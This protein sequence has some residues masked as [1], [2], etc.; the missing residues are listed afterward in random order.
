MNRRLQRA[1]RLW[2]PLRHPPV[3]CRRGVHTGLQGEFLPASWFYY[4]LTAHA[5]PRLILLG[6]IG[7][8]PTLMS[9]LI[10]LE[11]RFVF[12]GF[13]VAAWITACL[14]VGYIWRPRLTVGVEIPARVEAGSRFEIRYSV[15]NTGR[16]TARDLGVDT[17]VYSD[18]R[19]LRLQPAAIDRVPAG[20]TVLASGACRAL[21]RGSYFLPGLRYDSGFPGGLWRWGRTDPSERPLFVYPRYTRLSSFEIPLG[22]R[23]RQELSHA[24]ERAREA[25]EFH[26]CREFRDGDA[27]RHVHPRSSAR[28]GAPVVKEFQAEGRARTAILVDTRRLGTCRQAL[29]FLRGNDPVEAGLSIA[30]AVVDALAATD[31]VLELLVAGP[32]V[33]RFRSAGRVGYLSEALDILAAVEP[34]RADPL[35]RL[36]P[37]L[38]EEIRQIQSVCLILTSWDA[39]RAELIRRLEAWDTGLKILLLSQG[40]GRPPGFPPDGVCLDARAVLRGEEVA[41]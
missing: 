2:R 7:L 4:W 20:A 23:H 11:S 33:Y 35:D 19:C 14:I 28:V 17:L 32:D 40:K 27:L 38:F 21:R 5:T 39:R 22:N 13:A 25:L 26:G 29:A 12:V 1:F 16:W 37:L 30:A 8:T 15:T 3:G 34:V 36:E 41:L 9:L 6:L 24:N 10:G 31:R 18:W